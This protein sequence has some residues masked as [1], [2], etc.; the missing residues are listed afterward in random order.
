MTF[1]EII[2][3]NSKAKEAKL[4]TPATKA[5]AA[6]DTGV[7]I[8][9]PAAYHVIKD[10]ALI[11]MKYLPHF[12]FG[13]YTDPFTELRGKMTVA[14]I[15]DFINRA[16]ADVTTNQLFC[17][18]NEKIKKT[19]TAAVATQDDPY[20]DYE[21]YTSVSKEVDAVATFSK[22]FNATA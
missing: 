8:L 17:L 21:S 16:F 20:G 5:S 6:P 2:V 10:C 7:Q 3:Q 19:P 18:I 1:E 22:A 9:N 13:L 14:Q 15:K 4:Y 12:V 11:T